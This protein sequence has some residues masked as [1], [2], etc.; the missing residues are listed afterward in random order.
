[1]DEIARLKA[2]AKLLEHELDMAKL[3][4]L[5]WERWA[6]KVGLPKYCA[7]CHRELLANDPKPYCWTCHTNH[8]PRVSSPFVDG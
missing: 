8:D 1:M 2:E 6:E 7:V 5:K 4:V 3:Q